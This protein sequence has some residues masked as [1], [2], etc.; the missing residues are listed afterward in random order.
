LGSTQQTAAIE[1]GFDA[2]K[3]KVGSSNIERD[4]RR[5]FLIRKTV[6]DDAR[7]MLDVNQQWS[8]PTALSMCRKLVSIRKWPFF[9]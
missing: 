8:L 1:Q 2:M 6:G 9:R 5:A 4:I 3:L 7:I